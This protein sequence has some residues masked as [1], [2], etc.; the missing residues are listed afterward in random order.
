MSL[1]TDI[2]SAGQIAVRTAWTT[3][4]FSVA[5]NRTILSGLVADCAGS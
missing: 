4:T 2:G 3:V 1:P 5:E